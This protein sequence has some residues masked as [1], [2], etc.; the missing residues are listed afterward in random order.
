MVQGKWRRI[1][2]QSLAGEHRWRTRP[3]ASREQRR[4][5]GNIK[6][7]RGTRGAGVRAGENERR[8]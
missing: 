7:E 8:R 1:P 3:A 2:G 4:R 5:G 6:P